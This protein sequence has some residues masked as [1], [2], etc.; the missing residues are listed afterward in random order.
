M[1]TSFHTLLFFLWGRVLDLIL[2]F[3][4]LNLVLGCANVLVG[5]SIWRKGQG[6]WGSRFKR[7]VEQFRRRRV[8]RG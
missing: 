5:W 2:A 6:T 3:L 4:I 8:R 1:I 7:I